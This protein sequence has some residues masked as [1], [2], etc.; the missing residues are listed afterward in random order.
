VLLAA[1]GW[2]ECC[3]GCCSQQPTE[4]AALAEQDNVMQL[5]LPAGSCQQHFEVS[6]NAG[7]SI[8]Q[9]HS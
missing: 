7:Q 5:S 3:L 4:E 9:T 2:F 6:V 8:K 1:V